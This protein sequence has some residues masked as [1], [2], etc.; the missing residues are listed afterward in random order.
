[1]SE[2]VRC[3]CRVSFPNFEFPISN[4]AF[5]PHAT[6]YFKQEDFFFRRELMT[7][8]LHQN[9]AVHDVGRR[10]FA[11]QTAA[12]VSNFLLE[13]RA[14]IP[15]ALLFV[16]R[17]AAPPRI[18][19]VTFIGPCFH[20]V[21]HRKVR[22]LRFAR[23]KLPRELHAAVGAFPLARD[24]QT[25]RLFVGD[26]RPD[27]APHPTST[28]RTKDRHGNVIFFGFAIVSRHPV[29]VVAGFAHGSAL[30][31]HRAVKSCLW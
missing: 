7:Q 25:A 14:Q 26:G 21:E 19:V 13:L 5:F 6:F 4:D 31:A 24:P 22:V 27:R 2:D 23:M 3:V 17:R 30:L 15:P 12:K 28:I 10:T 1:M 16:A 20:A 9:V 11:F 8:L 29:P 18:A